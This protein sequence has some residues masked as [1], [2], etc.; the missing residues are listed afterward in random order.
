MDLFEKKDKGSNITNKI[1][2]EVRK[3]KQF[4]SKGRGKT[5]KSYFIHEKKNNKNNN[6]NI[7]ENKKMDIE[8]K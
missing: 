4:K 5:K 2:K 3:K 6:S 8:P 1:G 7:E